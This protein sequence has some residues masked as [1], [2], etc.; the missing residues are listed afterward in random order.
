MKRI[1]NREDVETLLRT[2]HAFIF[3]LDGTLWTEDHPIP[4]KLSNL[5][6]QVQSKLP[7]LMRL[8]LQLSLVL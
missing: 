3:D 7:I 5:L 6:S 4:G 8:N 2:T 1:L